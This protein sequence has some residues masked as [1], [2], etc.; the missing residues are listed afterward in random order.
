VVLSSSTKTADGLIAKFHMKAVDFNLAYDYYWLEVC[1]ALASAER[2]RAIPTAPLCDPPVVVQLV[3][4][5]FAAAVISKNS[6]VLV[7]RQSIGTL[8]G[9]APPFFILRTAFL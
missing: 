4:V 3:V 6:L 8:R 9:P 1:K 5:V 2:R 7:Q